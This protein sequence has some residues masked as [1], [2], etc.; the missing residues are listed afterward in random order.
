VLGVSNASGVTETTT[1]ALDSSAV[2][3]VFMPIKVGVGVK[4]NVGV[5][6]VGEERGVD[7]LVEVGAG[8]RVGTGAK[9]PPQAMVNTALKKSG[10]IFFMVWVC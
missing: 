9:I 7:V 1:V 10:N 2:V 4:V 5:T 6:G 8:V 3:G